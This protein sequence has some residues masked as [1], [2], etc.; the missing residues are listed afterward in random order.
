VDAEDPNLLWFSKQVIEAT[1]VEMSDLF[2]V[3]IPSTTATQIDTGPVRSIG[4]MDDKLIIGKRNAFL[5]INGSGPDN[6][7]ANNQ[8]SPATLITT[9]VGCTNQKSI[10]QTP[11]G[12]MFQSNKGIWRLKRDLQT[13]YVGAPVQEF[14]DGAVVT[15]AVSVPGTNQVRFVLDTGVT[16]TYDYFY[17]QWSTFTGATSISS[18]I[19]GEAHTLLNRFGQVSQQQVGVYLDGS[20]PVLMRFRTGPLRLGDLQGYQRAYFFYLL[21]TYISPHK[22]MLAMSFD[23]EASP[24]QQVLI[25]PV[26]G[27]LP[28][29]SGAAQS[30]FG[31]GTPF[32]G[33][34]SEENWRIFLSQQR[35]SA[36][37]ITMQEVY[38][39]SM[40]LAAGQGLTLSGL[41]VV[42]G[43][44]KGYRPQDAQTSAG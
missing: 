39:P 18:C 8:Y 30:P 41:N 12:L 1:P 21:G 2:T 20:S 26:N 44:K 19:Y 42:C 11:Q 40:G 31:Q 33:P 14:T 27:S 6:T 36:F 24:S 29:G 5:Y 9:T 34:S 43:F 16:V 7:G 3:Y 35:C 25:T 32:G 37:D 22:L 17:D 28:F 13:D 4:V 15:S 38:D 10:V 23:Y